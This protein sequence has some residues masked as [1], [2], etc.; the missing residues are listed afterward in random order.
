MT[1]GPSAI[2]FDLDDTLAAT[3]PLWKRAETE[4]LASLGRN[5]EPK[6]ARQYKG[7]NALDVAATIHR[8]L[9]PEESKEEC[10][11]RMREA[12][13][14]SFEEGPLEPMP[15]AIGAVRMCSDV[16]PLA[17]ASGSPLPLI[18]IVLERLEFPPVFQVLISSESVAK[19]KPFP[20]V[21]LKIGR[22]HV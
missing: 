6:L 8:I 21:F 22:A 1:G 4:L 3:S 9:E 12:L 16:A 11:K 13:F 19:G 18:R 2:I 7:M 5:W 15:G 10:Q 17:L 14:R 20:D